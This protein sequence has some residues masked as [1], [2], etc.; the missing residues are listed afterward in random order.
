MISFKDHYAFD[1]ETTGLRP[2]NG[3]RIFSFCIA[4]YKGNVD[5]YQMNNRGK[6]V[7]KEFWA[8]KT[9]QK[10]MHHGKF[11]M[12]FLKYHDVP[13]PKGTIIHDTMIASQM[14]RNLAP[15][16]SL[17]GLAWELCGYPKDLDSDIKKEGKALGGYDKIP[18][19]KMTK[20]QIADGQ[21]TMLLHQG[22]LPEILESPALYQDYLVEMEL[23]FVTMRLEEYGIYIHRKNCNN[24]INHLNEELDYINDEAYELLGYRAN[25]ASNQQLQ[26]ILFKRLNLPPLK[27]TKNG[28]SCDMDTINYLRESHPHPILDLILKHRTYTKGVAML[29]SYLE[30]AGMT[31]EGKLFPTINTNGAKKTGRESSTNPN[32]QNVS[33]STNPRNPYTVAARKAFKAP[34]RHILF[35]V[36][37]SG[38]EMRLIVDA[39]NQK[40]LMKIIKVGGDVHMPAVECFYG[41]K[42]S[43]RERCIK[44]MIKT[45]KENKKIIKKNVKKYGR[46]QG[47]EE[48]WKIFKKVLRGAAKNAHFGMAYGASLAKL[49]NTL[50]LSIIDTKIGFDRYAEKYPE[51]AYF[52][53]NIAKEV[54]EK[55]YVIT[56]FGRKLYV[57]K[58]KAYMGANYKIQGTAGG[59]IKRAQIKVDKWTSKYYPE[60]RIN[61]PIHDEIIMSY[62]LKYINKQKFLLPKISKLMT[63][64]PGIKVRLDVEW[65]R[66]LTTWDKAKEIEVAY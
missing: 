11:D 42:F 64:I 66:T 34:P 20:Y 28:P 58:R 57:N 46:E 30:L 29:N 23:I 65:K 49:A 6:K 13:I 60:I 63:N 51:V 18:K 16:H 17:D 40:E 43:N 7:L 33:K 2:H 50:S 62:P 10:V 15:T 25:I 53:Q 54:K 56:A 14:L 9:K 4:D 61:I 27:V 52:T 21:R 32:L 48:S 12:S 47:L 3:D 59:V 37:Y 36:D 41:S 5:V 55:G 35:L 39:C 19:K 8:D 22:F 44:H 45:N 26:S 1:V 38:I 31:K 24:L